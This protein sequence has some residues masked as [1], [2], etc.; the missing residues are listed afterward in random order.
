MSDREK[1]T[2]ATGCPIADNQNLLTAG[3]RR[4]LLMQNFLGNACFYSSAARSSYGYKTL[5][6]AL[7]C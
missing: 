3:A 2:T 7:L 6:L 4:P 1:L 5:L